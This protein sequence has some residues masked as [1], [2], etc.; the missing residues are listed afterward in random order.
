MATAD[1]LDRKAAAE[2][3]ARAKAEKERLA[4]AKKRVAKLRA[5]K[6]KF[7][8]IVEDSLQGKAVL[9]VD[10]KTSAEVGRLLL[11][12]LDK[13]TREVAMVYVDPSAR[14]QGLATALFLEAKK[15]GL[16]PAHSP[17]R[18][19]EGDFFAKSTGNTVPDRRFSTPQLDRE[20]AKYLKNQKIA[21]KA[22]GQRKA[23]E[24]ARE[25]AA[26]AAS[27]KKTFS[28]ARNLIAGAKIG[29]IDVPG[30]PK[31]G[32][33]PSGKLAPPPPPPADA[34]GIYYRTPPPAPRPPG[35]VAGL[36][37]LNRLS[38][39]LG[40]LP[41]ILGGAAQIANARKPPAM[42]F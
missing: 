20:D 41:T 14:R 9:A 18:T 2:K 33:A 24:L 23:I 7:D 28:D 19:L 12:P 25:K 40:F 21:D 17:K 35:I 36:N 22:K 11:N 26:K 8:F 10:K 3:A 15:A 1:S 37:A 34:P 32:G 13:G 4:E 39:P 42:Q 16:K 38:G 27:I 30:I 29:S 6:G 5:S 31:G